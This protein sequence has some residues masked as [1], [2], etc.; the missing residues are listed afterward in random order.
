[1]SYCP[2]CGYDFRKKNWVKESD[3]LL[4]RYNHN[5]YR[6]IKNLFALCSKHE[7]IYPEDVYKFLQGISQIPEHIVFEGL[8]TFFKN[9]YHLTKGIKYAQYLILNFE[10][11][12]EHISRRLEKTLGGK[13]LELKDE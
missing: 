1:M 6:L 5:T 7:E 12:K 10:K 3:V 8:K 11:N 9:E 13:S 4:K 2:C